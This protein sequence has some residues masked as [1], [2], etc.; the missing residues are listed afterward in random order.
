MQTTDVG[1]LYQLL[2]ESLSNPDERAA[3]LAARPPAAAGGT[4]AAA[5][6]AATG[7]AAQ[8]TPEAVEEATRRLAAY[9]GPIAKVVAKKAAAQANG[10]RHFHELLAGQLTDPG[11]RA[12]FL[13]EVGAD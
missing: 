12:R 3:F 13:H 6:T 4:A 9:L 7:V 5:R 11:E 1:Q 8:L 2:A 10:R